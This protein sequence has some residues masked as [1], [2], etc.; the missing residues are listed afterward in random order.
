[1]NAC[2]R[3]QEHLAAHAGADASCCP[4]AS[5][6]AH[7]TTCPECRQFATEMGILARDLEIAAVSHPEPVL[8][9]RV[10]RTVTKTIRNRG[11]ERRSAI[12]WSVAFAGATAAIA[13]LI[14]NS[15]SGRRSHS[16]Q[17]SSMQPSTEPARKAV[18]EPNLSRYQSAFRR[19]TESLDALLEDNA[20]EEGPTPS[21]T[22][23]FA[24]LR[25]G[26]RME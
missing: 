26:S 10:Q 22:E 25:L 21:A 16:T 15:H 13:L 24:T 20:V 17:L 19:S 5:L 11:Q 6:A 2:T 9:P 3:H 12:A 23:T 18:E 14:A 7:L 4:D 1:M 8:S